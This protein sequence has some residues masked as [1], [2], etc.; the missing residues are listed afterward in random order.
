MPESGDSSKAAHE[1]KQD[2]LSLLKIAG[3][4]W[5]LLT[6]KEKSYFLIRVAFRLALNGIDVVAVALMGLLGAITIAV[7]QSTIKNITNIARKSEDSITRVVIEPNT[8]EK[9]AFVE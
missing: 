4:S 9:V 8:P 7:D 6:G 5:S 1:T 2:F 3:I